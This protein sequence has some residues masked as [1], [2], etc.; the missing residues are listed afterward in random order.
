MPLITLQSAKGFG[1]GSA[2]SA[3][4]NSYESIATTTVGSGG[5]STIT[6]SSIPS[7]YTHLQIRALSLSA[8]GTPEITINFNNDTGG[9]NYSQHALYGTGSSVGA[10]AATSQ[11]FMITWQGAGGSTSN[12]GTN[13]I[14]IL[15]YKNT[16][17]Y[18][19]MRSF[20]GRDNNGSGTVSLNSGV[21]LNNAAI[22]TITLKTQT[23]VNFAEYSSFAL[24]GIKGA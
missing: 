13:I 8:S 11:T 21:W 9:S 17:K 12:P 24:Y 14:D 2:S 16:N 3:I 23:A 4:P 6:F 10:Y 7:T 18:T 15:D 5:S 1:F 20:T 22:T 19:T